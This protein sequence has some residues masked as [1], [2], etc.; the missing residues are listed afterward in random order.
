MGESLIIQY[1]GDRP[2]MQNKIK[3]HATMLGLTM[4]TVEKELAFGKK[5][6]A[7]GP[8][9]KRD[10]RKRSAKEAKAIIAKTV[11]A[12]AKKT[13]QAKSTKPKPAPSSN[14]A[15]PAPRLAPSPAPTLPPLPGAGSEGQL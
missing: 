15:L 5:M 1:L 14:K 11:S 7:H 3:A 9:D 13:V 8:R 4:P 10:T 12:P 2:A 6:R